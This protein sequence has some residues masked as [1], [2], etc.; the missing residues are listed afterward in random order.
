MATSVAPCPMSRSGTPRVTARR[1]ARLERGVAPVG[2]L[3]AGRGTLF[4]WNVTDRDRAGADVARVDAVH[5]LP[6]V[7]HVAR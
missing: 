4:G 2:R 3:G 5:Q 7:A 1:M 6:Q